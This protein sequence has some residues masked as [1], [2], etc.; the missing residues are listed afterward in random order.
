VSEG[1]DPDRLIALVNEGGRLFLGANCLERSLVW[2]R[3]FSRLGL[4]PRLVMGARRDGGNI[5]GHVWVE[6]NGEPFGETD[7]GRYAT[8]V[9]FAAHGQ[10]MMTSG[11]NGIA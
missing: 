5:A 2:Y 6:L 4:E 3:L 7:A 10:Q 8:V 1:G 11:V 9:A